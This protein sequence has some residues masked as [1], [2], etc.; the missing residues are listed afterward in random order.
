[1]EYLDEA[2]A[3]KELAFDPIRLIAGI[4][5]DGPLALLRSC[6]AVTG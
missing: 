4:Q 2:A 5:L 6:H 1:M 3:E